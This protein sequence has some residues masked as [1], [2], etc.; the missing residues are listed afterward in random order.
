M[1]ICLLTCEA[2][3]L[4]DQKVFPPL[5][6]MA[7]GTALRLQGHE[8]AIKSA[9]DESQYFAMGPVT[10]EYPDALHKLHQVKMRENGSH[11]IIGGPHAASNVAECLADGF[12][13]VVL[14]D[15]EN[16]CA[17][18]FSIRGVV[19]LERKP[20]DEYPEIDRSLVSI[21]DYHYEI[22]NRLS[23]TLLTSRGCPY[24]CGFCAKTENKIRYRGIDSIEAEVVHLK[25]RWG[26]GA[27]MFFDDTLTLQKGR[28]EHICRILKKHGMLW[29]CFVRGDLVVRHGQDLVDLMCDS[30]C[31]EVGIG[32]ESGS[33]EILQA[34]HKGESL[35]TIR[36][37]LNMLHRGHIRTKGFFILGLPGE[38][39]KTIKETWQLL[40][41]IH[42]DDA[43]FTVY[44]PFPNSDIWQN[45]ESYDID[46]DILPAKERFY[47]GRTGE[48][49]SSVRT[50]SLS[51]EEIIQ[52]R[53]GLERRFRC[54]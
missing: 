33:E 21:K 11:V 31:V 48:Y 16:I 52:A 35:S 15:G 39:S 43:D 51:S 1:K 8:V 26:Y 29:R 10:P 30:G 13:T 34:I 44:Q 27:L 38:S 19:S 37:A 5:G 47:K 2:P 18:T 49:R 53:D 54:R 41:E 14:G 22:N 50:S 3:F 36:Q 6:L 42:L 20:L 32:V 12:N 7:V 9:P 4:I 17:G 24:S 40:E 23:T 45:R 25:E 46:W 28:A